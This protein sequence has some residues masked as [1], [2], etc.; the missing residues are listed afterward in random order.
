MLIGSRLIHQIQCFV[1]YAMISVIV[2][3]L[4]FKLLAHL[5][6]LRPQLIVD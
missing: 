4:Y 5:L 3:R 6:N 1:D 2:I